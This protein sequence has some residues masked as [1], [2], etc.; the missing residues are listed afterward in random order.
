VPS[1]FTDHPFQIGIV[2]PDLE[3]ALS[4]YES[5]FGPAEW[6]IVENGP[7]NLHGLHL[8]GL[9]AEFSMRLALRGSDPQLELLQ[10]LDG[11]DILR[12]GWS[13]AV[14]G[15]IS[16]LRGALARRDD[17]A[18]GAGGV[19]VR[20]ARLRPRC[21]RLGR[22]RVLRTERELGYLVE[23]IEPATEG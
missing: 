4:R 21:E 8:R 20:P 19:R 23:A 11:P 18:D 10:P 1:P 2:V 7:H 3:Q 12:S 9:P 22:L 5:V 15:S 13:G 17:R 16:R 6:L 14:K